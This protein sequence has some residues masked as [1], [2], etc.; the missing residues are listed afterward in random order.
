MYNWYR[1]RGIGT[2]TQPWYR[3]IPTL[4]LQCWTIE[5]PGFKPVTL[6]YMHHH[7]LSFCSEGDGSSRCVWRVGASRQ[8]AGQSTVQNH[9]SHQFNLRIHANVE[10]HSGRG[11]S[12][13]R[14]AAASDGGRRRLCFQRS[15]PAGESSELKGVCVFFFLFKFHDSLSSFLWLVRKAPCEP[16]RIY[17]FFFF[18]ILSL[19]ETDSC[20]LPHPPRR[21]TAKNIHNKHRE[22]KFCIFFYLFI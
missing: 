4:Q 16:R 20:L 6:F 3:C 10:W 17:F 14:S 1:R 9:C 11:R 8:D 19:F 18:L 12:A 21:T 15:S 13:W 2:S 5:T 7:M 22:M